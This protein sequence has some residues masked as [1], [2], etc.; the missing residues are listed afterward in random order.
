MGTFE[1][2]H[3]IICARTGMTF[4]ELQL[5]FSLKR[6]NE[7]QPAKRSKST[8]TAAEHFR[9]ITDFKDPIDRQVRSFCAC[10]CVAWFC[11]AY[12][13]YLV[14]RS[15]EEEWLVA[16]RSPYVGSFSLLSSSLVHL[17]VSISRRAGAQDE[18]QEDHDESSRV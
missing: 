18:P 8:Q 17:S 4:G 15:Q 7:K 3:P 11:A 9:W 14:V 6:S 1:E 5:R 10:V 12:V 16:G 13:G 2:W